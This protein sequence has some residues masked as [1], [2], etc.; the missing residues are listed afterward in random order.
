M[1]YSVEADLVNG[2]LRQAAVDELT[3]P[4]ALIV[5]ADSFIDSHLRG[6]YSLPLSSTPPEIKDASVRIT[7][8]YALQSLGWD[9]EMGPD[10]SIK[11]GYHDTVKWLDK[12]S[13]GKVS[14]A[15]TADSS[16]TVFEGGPIV[17][18][19]PG[20]ANGRRI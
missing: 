18:S 15:I 2:G 13:S 20:I 14:L 16:S 1:P 17:R 6:R 11:S 7:M 10:E 3:D 19:Q 9:P 5:R 12:L 4:A 8:W